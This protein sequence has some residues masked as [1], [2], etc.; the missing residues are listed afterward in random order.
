M[1]SDVVLSLKMREN[2]IKKLFI[3]FIILINK[4]GFFLRCVNTEDN[5]NEH[6]EIG[7]VFA[8]DVDNVHVGAAPHER[9]SRVVTEQLQIVDGIL[10]LSIFIVHF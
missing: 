9:L 7:D 5:R 2:M 3:E 10:I 8:I 1:D 4:K 6:A